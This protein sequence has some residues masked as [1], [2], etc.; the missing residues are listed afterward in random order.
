M[1]LGG[2]ISQCLL[3]IKENCPSLQHVNYSHKK[4]FKH[5]LDS[6]TQKIPIVKSIHKLRLDQE[7]KIYQNIHKI[8]KLNLMNEIHQV[9][10]KL[11]NELKQIQYDQLTLKYAEYKQQQ[12]QCTETLSDTQDSYIKYQQ[13]LDNHGSGLKIF[14]HRPLIRN[15]ME[16]F[17]QEDSI[18]SDSYINKYLDLN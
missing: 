13:Q 6:I 4:S 15:I 5:C 18:Y 12:E 3:E 8:K 14:Q 16:E 7:Q 17:D 1:I 10:P 9:N 11:H 2:A